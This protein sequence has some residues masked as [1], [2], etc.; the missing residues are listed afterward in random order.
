V[1]QGGT[2]EVVSREFGAPGKGRQRSSF[3]T[4]AASARGDS[5][6]ATQQKL[7]R[8]LQAIGGEP[9]L[10][11]NLT[12][13]IAGDGFRV[14]FWRLGRAAAIQVIWP[15]TLQR[16]RRPPGVVPA[17]E[18]GAQERQVVEALD[19]R[20]ASQPLVLKGLDDP[21][22]DGDGSVLW[23]WRPSP[24]W[25]IASG[26]AGEPVPNTALRAGRP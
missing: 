6:R 26:F 2:A 15:E 23:L 9:C 11:E 7:R 20:H 18:L 13:D 14:S 22:G 4:S 8:V 25:P 5:V 17:L 24:W 1:G 12:F 19:K 10:G 16:H 3:E 21:L